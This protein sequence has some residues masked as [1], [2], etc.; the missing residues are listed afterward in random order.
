MPINPKLKEHLTQMKMDENYRQSLI[1]TLEDAPGDVQNL[2]LGQAEVTRQ[3]NELKTEKAAWK[4]KADEFYTKSET[5]IEAWKGEVQKANAAVAA[6]QA[7]IAEL[8]AGGGPPKTAAE[9]DAVAKEIKALK[10]AVTSFESKMGKAVTEEQLNK[11]YQNAVGYIGDSFLDTIEISARHQEQFGKRMT[12]TEI[13]ELIQFANEKSKALGHSI[14]LED[15]Y[16]MKYGEDLKK[17][18]HDAI[19]AKAIEEYKTRHELP[20]GAA[21]GGA[22]PLEKGPLQI[23]LDQERQLAAGK[24]EGYYTDWRE[25]AAAAGDELVKEGKF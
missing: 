24:K 25:A 6:A 16:G 10:D 2:W 19:A 23:R 14:T 15:A 20:T 17:K 1:A 4:T 11:A 3:L 7:R 13:G 21:P 9:E 18:E 12:K 22:P 5:A 8:E